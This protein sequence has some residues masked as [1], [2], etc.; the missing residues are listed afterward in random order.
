MYHYLIL[1]KNADLWYSMSSGEVGGYVMENNIAGQRFGRLVASKC[2]ERRSKDGSVFWICY[3][4]CG[5]VT[6]ASYGALQSGAATSC[7]CGRWIGRR[8]GWLE[9]VDFRQ[10][11]ATLRCTCGKQLSLSREQLGSQ[12]SCG[13]EQKMKAPLDGQVSLF[14]VGNGVAVE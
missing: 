6:A 7:G 13:C 10:G 9:V 11:I 2:S 4:A 5:N 14:P 8:F 12:R 1:F 3:C